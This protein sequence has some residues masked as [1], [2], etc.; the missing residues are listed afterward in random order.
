MQHA[1]FYTACLPP[2]LASGF[3]SCVTVSPFVHSGPA[4][5]I[6]HDTV[7]ERIEDDRD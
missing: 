7:I 5:R 4:S 3:N 1:F 6:R 2:S